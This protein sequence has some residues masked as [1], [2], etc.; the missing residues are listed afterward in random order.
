MII[1]RYDLSTIS[2]RYWMKQI[3]IAAAAALSA[4]GPIG[5]S[6]NNTSDT[7]EKKADNELTANGSVHQPAGSG[8]QKICF[9]V[10][11][12]LASEFV[13]TRILSTLQEFD[14]SYRQQKGASLRLHRSAEFVA[15]FPG[16]RFL[17]SCVPG[18]PAGVAQDRVRVIRITAREG[19]GLVLRVSDGQGEQRVEDPALEAPQWINS[20]LGSRIRWPGRNF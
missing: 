18:T 20:Y 17:E 1:S 3:A 7:V 9:V 14:A 6:N 13:L 4:C 15:R 12:Q 8:P 2:G 16:N 10:D 19:G 5:S 11:P